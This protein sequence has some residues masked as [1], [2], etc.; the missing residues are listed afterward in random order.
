MV[1]TIMRQIV[2]TPISQQE[3]YA[4]RFL[5]AGGEAFVFPENMLFIVPVSQVY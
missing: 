1:P 2:P 5:Y 3:E 4:Q